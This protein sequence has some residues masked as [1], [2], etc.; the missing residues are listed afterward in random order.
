[1]MKYFLRWCPTNRMHFR[2]GH[3][4]INKGRAEQVNRG[5]PVDMLQTPSSQH[6]NGLMNVVP[7]NQLSEFLKLTGFTRL[8]TDSCWL[9]TIRSC[10]NTVNTW[11]GWGNNQIRQSGIRIVVH[12]HYF[13]T[14]STL[15]KITCQGHLPACTNT[16]S[17]EYRWYY[18]NFSLTPLPTLLT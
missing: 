11:P 18:R 17:L 7:W 2:S 5:F 8:N 1:M 15:L 6:Q 3:K 13:V 16:P 10:P 9:N 4:L 12:T 14:S